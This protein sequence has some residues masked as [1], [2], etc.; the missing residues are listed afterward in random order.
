MESMGVDILLGRGGDFVGVVTS[1]LGVCG[2]TGGTSGGLLGSDGM[3]GSG[4]GLGI[5][6]NLTLDGPTTHPIKANIILLDLLI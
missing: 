6:S 1:M 3:T 4:G 2:V 5:F